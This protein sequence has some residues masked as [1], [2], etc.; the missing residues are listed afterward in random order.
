MSKLTLFNKDKKVNKE[1]T[2]KVKKA[3]QPK[4]KVNKAKQ[5][6]EKTEKTKLRKVK[7]KKAKPEAEGKKV[8]KHKRQTA[9]A[10]PTK[11]KKIRMPLWWRKM[12]LSTIRAKLISGFG[13]VICLMIVL[14]TVLLNQLTTS[15]VKSY[16]STSSKH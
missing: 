13:I 3:R 9:S 14:S 1:P 5:P 2:D 8:L 12:G 11:S 15:Q 4:E 7:Q 10:K 16:E 6:K